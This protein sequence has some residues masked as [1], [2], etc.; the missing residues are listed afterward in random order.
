MSA[1]AAWRSDLI[2][3]DYPGFG[4]SDWPDPATRQRHVGL[5]PDVDRYNPDLWV[6]EYRFLIDPSQ[7]DRQVDLF[8]DYRANVA[9]VL[10]VARGSFASV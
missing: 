10:Q 7:G 6:D 9:S 5:D 8:Y 2:A 4:H 3:S 1:S